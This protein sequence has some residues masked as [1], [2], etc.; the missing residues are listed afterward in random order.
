MKRCRA[1]NGMAYWLVSVLAAFACSAQ[2]KSPTPDTLHGATS[3]PYKMISGESLLLHVFE[4]EKAAPGPRPALVLF[5]GGAWTQGSVG[6]F[7]TQAKYLSKRGMVVVLADYRVFSR[8][9]STGLE[10]M[11]DAASAMRWVRAHASDL[12]VD[13]RRIAAGGGSA[14]GQ[15]ALSTALMPEFADPSEDSQIS[16]HPDALVLFNP[17]VDVS[18]FRDRFGDSVHR[19]SPLS[20]PFPGLPPTLILHGRADT[21][22]PYRDVEKFCALAKSQGESCQVVGYDGATHGFFNSSKQPF[23]WKMVTLQEVDRFLT[24]LGYLQPSKAGR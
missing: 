22:A 21:V 16:A 20:R 1:L 3:Y 11:A 18:K 17:V 13:P 6:Q 7:V 5:F 8:Q 9:Q 15:L 2:G 24:Q 10:S 4:P 19:A 12:S 14:G 23:N